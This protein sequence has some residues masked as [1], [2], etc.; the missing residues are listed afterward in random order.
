MVAVGHSGPFEDKMAEEFQ[1]YKDILKREQDKF[2]KQLVREVRI[3]KFLLFQ[4][5]QVIS[6]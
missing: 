5:K 6:N 3:S 4:Q 2:R 1:K